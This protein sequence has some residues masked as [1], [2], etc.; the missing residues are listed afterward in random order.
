[1]SHSLT[2]V[3]V[4][5]VWSTWRRTPWI[6]A[7]VE[8]TI[9]DAIAK[10]AE[11]L[12][13]ALHAFG[14]SDDHV[15]TLLELNRSTTLVVLVRA[16]KGASGRVTNMNHRELNFRWQEGYGAF[17]VSERD[18]QPVIEYIRNQ[19]ERHATGAIDSDWEPTATQ[20]ADTE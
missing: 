13:C 15:H 14:A 8:R 2:R 6:D 3:Y 4:H 20:A 16:L 19:R 17:S 11:R 18:P 1:M 7:A 12:E 9:R 10:Q 5:L